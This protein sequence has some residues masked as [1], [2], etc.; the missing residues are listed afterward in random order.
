MKY[1]E[2]KK[3]GGQFKY[4]FP[5]L[6]DKFGYWTVINET[7]VQDKKHWKV[8]CECKCGKNFLVRVGALQQGLSKGCPCRSGDLTRGNNTIAYTKFHSK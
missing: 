2:K 8:L 6:N 7:P 5:K 4:E 1:M 3:T